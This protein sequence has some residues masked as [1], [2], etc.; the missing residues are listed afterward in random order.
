MQAIDVLVR[1]VVIDGVAAPA[2]LSAGDA[3][4][5]LSGLKAAIAREVKQRL[6]PRD[7]A[8]AH[9]GITS[10]SLTRWA[11]EDREASTPRRRAV[12]GLLHNALRRRYPEAVGPDELLAEMNAAGHCVRADELHSLTTIMLRLGKVEQLECGRFR[13]VARF[14]SEP[15]ADRLELRAQAI[16][17]RIQALPEMIRGYL[18]GDAAPAAS[19]ARMNIPVARHA[20]VADEVRA[21]IE[22]IYREEMSRPN[23]GSEPLQPMT[24]FFLSSQGW[25]G[26][27]DR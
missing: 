4:V 1:N 22:D 12:Q 25:L 17:R 13:A 21:A 24:L 2:A 10:R 16:Y 20:V 3:P 27:G 9:L 15:T 14:S 7:A 18:R 5:A 6:I 26:G 11:H 23:E 19:I 8:A